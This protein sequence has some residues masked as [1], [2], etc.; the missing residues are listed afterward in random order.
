MLKLKTVN[1]NIVSLNK[2][3]H[4]HIQNGLKWAVDDWQFEMHTLKWDCK[5]VDDVAIHFVCSTRT[6]VNELWDVVQPGTFKWNGSLFTQLVNWT[7]NS[8]KR[9]M[10]TFSV[11]QDTI[12]RESQQQ[13]PFEKFEK[14]ANWKYYT[15]NQRTVFNYN[16]VSCSS[17]IKIQKN[18]FIYGRWIWS[19]MNAKWNICWNKYEFRIINKRNFET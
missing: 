7:I 1:P 16:C 12:Q 14:N 9:E 3:F 2:C 6:H 8:I 19:K 10:M 15:L 13:E 5:S 4:W 11:V 17:F 18:S